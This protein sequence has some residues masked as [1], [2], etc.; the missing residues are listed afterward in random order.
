[1]SSSLCQADQAVGKVEQKVEEIVDKVKD[2]VG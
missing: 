2:A 1:L